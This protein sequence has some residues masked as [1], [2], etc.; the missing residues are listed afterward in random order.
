M[1]GGT[2]SVTGKSSN[3]AGDIAS[4]PSASSPSGF[5]GIALHD[6][7]TGRWLVSTRKSNSGFIEEVVRLTPC[8]LASLVG[9]IATLDF[10]DSYS[11]S[12]GWVTFKSLILEDTCS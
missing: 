12:W 3:L 2:S 9:R 10:I 1:Q 8:D 11:G 5:L 7:E 6:V 4:V